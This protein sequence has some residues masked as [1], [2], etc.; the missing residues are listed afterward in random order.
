MLKKLLQECIK[1]REIIGSFLHYYRVTDTLLLV[2]LK[3]V[4]SLQSK[5]IEETNRAIKRCLNYLEIF[6][7]DA[8]KHSI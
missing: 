2:T 3:Y 7:N 1:M 6:P 4:S 8:I 5:A